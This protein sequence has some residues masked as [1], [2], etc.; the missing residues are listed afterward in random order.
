MAPRIAA[1]R[2]FAFPP[3][4]ACR[5]RH[6][7]AQSSKAIGSVNRLRTAASPSGPAAAS[8]SRRNVKVKSAPLRAMRSREGAALGPYSARRLQRRAL[9]SGGH[10]GQSWPGARHRATAT[11]RS[12]D[13]YALRGYMCGRGSVTHNPACDL[14]LSERTGRPRLGTMTGPLFFGTP[15]SAI[16]GAP[17]RSPIH[18][19]SDTATSPLCART[20]INRR[21]ALNVGSSRRNGSHAHFSAALNAALELSAP[22]SAGAGYRGRRVVIRTAIILF[23]LFI[24]PSAA[25]RAMFDRNCD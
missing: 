23:L 13:H 3:S 14:P 22:C 12:Q 9:T 19:S 15:P 6:V 18:T 24:L 20:C 21:V 2:S 16:S 11:C 8:H 1:W 4:S 17:S 7:A 5:W 10:T 25:M